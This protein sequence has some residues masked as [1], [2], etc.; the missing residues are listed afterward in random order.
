MAKIS[1]VNI[2]RTDMGDQI[3]LNTGAALQ[4]S[5]GSGQLAVECGPW[6][7]ETFIQNQTDMT[8][9]AGCTLY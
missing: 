9:T 3:H 4:I 1:D 2:N 8:I 6:E 5:S 7:S